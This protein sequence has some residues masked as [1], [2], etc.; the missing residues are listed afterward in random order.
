MERPREVAGT[1]CGDESVPSVGWEREAGPSLA[2]RNPAQRVRASDVEHQAISIGAEEDS[3]GG[4]SF[5]PDFRRAIENCF[6]LN[7][8][9]H[10]T[11]RTP[12]MFSAFVSARRSCIWAAPDETCDN[13]VAAPALLLHSLRHSWFFRH[14]LARFHSNNSQIVR[15]IPALG[16]R[17]RAD[18]YGLS[19]HQGRTAQ[20]RG[21]VKPKRIELPSASQRKRTRK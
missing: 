3:I 11:S 5:T 9:L 21:Q 13:G 17:L 14:P 20:L 6:A 2:C 4:C 12:P 19:L 1:L 16:H 10:V 8:D 18:F 7:P 15:E